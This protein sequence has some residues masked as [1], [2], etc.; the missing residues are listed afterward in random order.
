MRP[1]MIK[2]FQEGVFPITTRVAVGRFPAPLR[3]AYLLD[4]NYTHILNVSDATSLASTRD[5]GFAEVKDL[6]MDDFV[7]IPTKDALEAAGT[8][9]AM[10][11]V[12]DSLVY[13][14]CIAGHMRSPTVLWLYLVGLGMDKNAAKQMITE[15]SPDAQPG[16]DTLVDARLVAS[17][18]E[19]GQKLG[20]IDRESLM[21]PAKS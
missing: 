13:I 6:Y 8:L 10:L 5:A 16:H 14:H 19:W 3:C 1:E 17:V 12:P 7:R 15:R 9:H 21:K 20:Y 2:A 18:K 11:N 4:Q